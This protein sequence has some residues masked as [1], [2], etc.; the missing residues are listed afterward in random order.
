MSERTTNR[1]LLLPYVLPY[2]LY[3]LV[4]SVPAD[5]LSREGNYAVRILLAGGAL[6][7]GW[8]HY[9][10]LRGPGRVVPSIVTGVVA[11]LVGTALWIALVLPF[12][13][14]AG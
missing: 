13:P 11:G 7:W 4:A 5:V 9:A 3:V 8:R 1:D 6:A 14:P 10:R 12:D 2:A